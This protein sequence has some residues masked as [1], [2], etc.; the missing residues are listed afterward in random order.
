MHTCYEPTSCCPRK[1]QQSFNLIAIKPLKITTS[2][3]HQCLDFFKIRGKKWTLSYNT[4]VDNISL[5]Y[6]GHE[7]SSSA[8]NPSGIPNLYQLLWMWSFWKHQLCRVN[9]LL[10]SLAGLGHQT[11][12]NARGVDVADQELSRLAWGDVTHTSLR[13]LNTLK[14]GYCKHWAV[15]SLAR[16]CC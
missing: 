11:A 5:S 12:G 10:Q 4:D 14:G 16:L 7:L 8:R 13:R 15:A 9:L 3:Q 2:K 6:P 1:S